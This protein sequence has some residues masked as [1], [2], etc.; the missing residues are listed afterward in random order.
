MARTECDA[1]IMASIRNKT[2]EAGPEPQSDAA[3]AVSQVVGVGYAVLDYLGIV[4]GM[5][6]FDDAEAITVQDWTASGGGPV[7]TALV[8]LARLGVPVAY[9]GLLGDDAAGRQIR[10]ELA[11]EGVDVQSLRHQSSVR[12]ATVLVLVEAGTGRRAFVAFKDSEPAFALTPEDSALITEARFLH[13]DGWYPDTAFQAARLART[14]GVP[15]S[16]DAYRVTERTPEWVSLSDVLIATESFPRR[17][18]GQTDLAKACEV[19][20]SQGPSLVVTTL[21]ERGCFVAT[22]ETQ[23]QSPGFPVEVVDTTGAGDAF[24]GAFLYGLLQEWDLP[25]TARFANAVGALACRKLGGRASIPSLSEVQE[26][27]GSL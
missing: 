13:L 8:S 27:L 16:L 24:H 23:F 10:Q 25:S 12:S 15:V 17:Y 18:T 14:V 5:P 3:C 1:N 2:G 6:R 21:S 22:K 19:L 11:R 9:V 7:S 4:P 26:F 20:L